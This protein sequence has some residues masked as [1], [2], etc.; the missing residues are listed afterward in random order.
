[1]W[2]MNEQIEEEEEEEVGY[3]VRGEKEKRRKSIMRAI[4]EQLWCLI[5]LL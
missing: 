3:N 1:M 2:K 4:G 5:I